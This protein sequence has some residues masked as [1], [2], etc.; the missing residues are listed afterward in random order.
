[1][2]S[3]WLSPQTPNKHY[4]ANVLTVLRSVSIP[5]N[6][7]TYVLNRSTDAVNE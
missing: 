3:D 7:I 4:S 1:M 2:Q 6:L 5:M